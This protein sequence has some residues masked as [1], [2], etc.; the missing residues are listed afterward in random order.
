MQRASATAHP[1][2]GS[3]GSAAKRGIDQTFRPKTV[4]TARVMMT[5]KV[6][7][8]HSNQRMT[9]M[10]A[11]VTTNTVFEAFI[12][13][14]KA[15]KELPAIREELDHT[16]EA[17]ATSN[18]EVI[19]LLDKL[20]AS[21]VALENLKASLSA[22]E[23]ELAHATFRADAVEAKHRA[24]RS[25]LSSGDDLL[26][27]VDG[28]LTETAPRSDNETVFPAS[29]P[30]S[31]GPTG[32]LSSGSG[33]ELRG[34]SED[35]P[36]PNEATMAGQ[37]ISTAQGNGDIVSLGQSDAD[38]T[39]PTPATNGTSLA[40]QPENP[41]SAPGPLSNPSVDAGESGMFIGEPASPS[42]SA[43]PL[44][45]FSGQPSTRK[46]EGME[47]GYWIVNGGEAPLWMSAYQ[48]ERL[49]QEFAQYAGHA[50]AAAE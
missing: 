11:N 28:A 19:G 16:K 22:R 48:E 49:R 15:M 34:Q 8:V 31:P 17:L 50:K 44:L 33:S 47:W 12:E 36:T 37:S 6:A 2:S 40:P 10:S 21:Q 42:P 35:N 3:L 39:S 32:S 25:I 43:S 45:A 7:K 5:T 13:A 30:Q 27:A 41:T 14:D 23:A 20:H 46:P 24:L 29:N 9:I 18:D 38:P 1:S 4:E 26:V